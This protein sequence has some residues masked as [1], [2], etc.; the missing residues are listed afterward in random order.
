MDAGFV[1]A[2]H[3][4]EQALPV[5]TAPARRIPPRSSLQHQGNRQQAPHLRRVAATPRYR[6]KL[7]RRVLKPCD[8]D[9]FAHPGLQGGEPPQWQ[10]R[11]VLSAPWEGGESNLTEV[12]I[13]AVNGRYATV[14]SGVSALMVA[15]AASPY[16]PVPF[17]I[18]KSHF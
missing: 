6:T 9:R 18:S 16:K 10:Q 11:I 1:V 3:P 8:R 2:M 7:F 4:V 17:S 14:V 12:S 5:D 15:T 13:S